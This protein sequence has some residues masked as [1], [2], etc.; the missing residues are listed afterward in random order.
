[1]RTMRHKRNKN[2]IRKL[3]TQT[4][5]GASL[6]GARRAPPLLSRPWRFSLALSSALP[7]GP[8]WAQV[9][10]PLALSLAMFWDLG[11]GGL[12]LALR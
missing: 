1:M 12:S 5:L 6:C 9:V 8:L 2:K 11:R 4:A 3:K 7:C 10:L